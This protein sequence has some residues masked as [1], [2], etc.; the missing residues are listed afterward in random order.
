MLNV[1]FDRLVTDSQHFGDFL[2]GQTESHLPKHFALALRKWHLNVLTEPW[3]RQSTGHPSQ[4]FPRP[5]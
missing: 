1:L 3:R 4:L 2:V 5:S